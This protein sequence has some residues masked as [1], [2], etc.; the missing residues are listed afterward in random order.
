MAAVALTHSERENFRQLPASFEEFA[1][2]G[3]EVSIAAT[4]KNWN[5]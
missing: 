2:L 4:S 5:I 1:E 3:M